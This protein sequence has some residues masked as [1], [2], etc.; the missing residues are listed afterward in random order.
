MNISLKMCF[1]A[2]LSTASIFVRTNLVCHRYHVLFYL[3]NIIT[4]KTY[5][6]LQKKSDESSRI[7]ILLKDE[8]KNALV[9]MLV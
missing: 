2:L 4:I 8:T 3:Y 5:K 6:K 9:W 1:C 7:L